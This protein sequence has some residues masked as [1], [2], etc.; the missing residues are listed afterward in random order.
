MVVRKPF[1]FEKFLWFI[2]SENYMV[3]A[4]RDAQQNELLVKRYLRAGDA[5]VHADLNGAATVVVKN[6]HKDAAIP[7]STLQ[8]A[9]YGPGV[10]TRRVCAR[11]LTPNERAEPGAPRR[12]QHHGHLPLVGM[13]LARRHRRVVG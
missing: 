1:W 2:S 13:G 3:L 5:Y 10:R 6:A 12:F 8:Q 9:G 7:P 11:E 4:G